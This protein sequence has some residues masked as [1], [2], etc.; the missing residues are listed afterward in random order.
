VKGDVGET[1]VV[2]SA[3]SEEQCGLRRSRGDEAVGVLLTRAGTG[4][5]SS[6]CAQTTAGELLDAKFERRGNR[7]KLVIGVLVLAAVL[8]YSY[9]RLRRRRR[10]LGAL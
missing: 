3:P 6:L 10:E 7:I 5:V 1:V 4:W 8:G 9:L 2:R